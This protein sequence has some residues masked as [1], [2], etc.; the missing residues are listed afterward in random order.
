MRKMLFLDDMQERHDS[1]KDQMKHKY[2]W[3]ITHVY[4][5]DEAIKKLQEESFDVVSLDHD[6]SIETIMKE[7]PLGEKSGYDVAMFISEMPE[8]KRP[9]NVVLHTWNSNGAKRMMDALKGKV[10]K[11]LYL[12]F[13]D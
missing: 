12:P 11:V 5:C 3:E 8:D 6:L 9:E 2:E 7:P 10:E 13:H 4:S 1:L